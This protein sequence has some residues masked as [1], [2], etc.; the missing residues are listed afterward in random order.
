MPRLSRR[1]SGFTLIE[2]LVVI[3]IIAVLIGL[4]LPAVQKVRQAAARLSSQNNLKQFG[5][6]MHSFHDSAGHFPSGYQSGL[7]NQPAPATDAAPGWGWGAQLLP[8]LEQDN[9]Y[10]QLRLNLPCWDPANAA[11]ASNCA[12]ASSW[13]PSRESS[14]PRT[15]GNRY[16]PFNP[17]RPSTMASAS[18]GPENMDTATARF[19]ST[20]GD[21]ATW[22]SASRVRSS[23]VGPSPPVAIT[24]SARSS[25]SR[26]QAT[27][28]ARSSA[29]VVWKATGM[30]ISPSR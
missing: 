13:R 21:G 9:L 5:L 2:L 30:P 18:A 6:A 23:S 26:K 29:T 7:P 19:R 4:L 16:D 25:A 15:L 22:A 10:R 3:A 11:A 14:S 27:L 17:A 1:R 24:T 20:T 28:S 8:Y 12:A